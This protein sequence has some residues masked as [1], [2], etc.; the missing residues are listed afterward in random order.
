MGNLM[1]IDSEKLKISVSSR[2]GELQSIKTKDGRE[3][4]WQGDSKYWSDRSPNIFPYVGR[5]WNNQYILEG[6]T[7]PLT[8]HGFINE[9]ELKVEKLNEDN[10]VLTYDATDYSRERYPY[11]FKYYVEYQIINNVLEITYR[12]KNLDTRPMYFGIGGHPGFNLPF[13]AGSDFEDHYIEFESG[14]KPIRVGFSSI[15]FV[16]GEDE[17]FLLDEKGQ[18]PLNHNLFDDDAI[19]LKECGNSAVLRSY[20]NEKAVKVVFPDMPYLGIWHRP[21]TD[22]PY[23]CI[24]PWSSLPSR[25]GE[26]PI[27][28][29]QSDLISLEPNGDYINK[30]SIEII[31]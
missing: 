5:L 28:E 30:W 8:I 19:V 29:E 26:V 12:V 15:C 6:K 10:L 21:K 20:K 17:P 31:E 24:E 14:S 2:G 22:A 18:L 27:F 9:Q 7:Y 3:W 25:H 1:V 23:V 11:N 13:E 4:L 16:N